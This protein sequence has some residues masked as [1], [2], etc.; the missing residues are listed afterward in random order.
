MKTKI[1]FFKWL[2]QCA[3]ILEITPLQMADKLEND[4]GWGMAY[5]DGNTPKQAVDSWK[6]YME[7]LPGN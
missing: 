3:G 4:A 2:N 7:N 6:E 1:E 5:D